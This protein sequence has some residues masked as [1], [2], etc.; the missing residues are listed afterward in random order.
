MNQ[1][2]N[3]P[4]E[5]IEAGDM[6]AIKKL[7]APPETLFGR[8]ATHSLYGRV[9]CISKDEKEED[10]LHVWI[11]FL[12]DEANGQSRMKLVPVAALE[13]DPLTLTTVEDFRN[14]PEG[15]I[16]SRVNLFPAEKLCSGNWRGYEDR[17]SYR[18]A[19]CGQWSV[20]R[21]GQV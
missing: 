21:W 6:E 14:A 10:D 16:V 18:M 19:E 13:F 15:T 5:L 8:W 20:V 9:M 4:R 17:N 1:T 12:D 2:V 3:V 7:I 11:T